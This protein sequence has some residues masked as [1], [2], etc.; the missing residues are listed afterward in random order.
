M[1]RLLA[2]IDK[3]FNKHQLVRR[4][5]ITLAWLTIGYVALHVLHQIDLI[6]EHAASVLNSVIGVCGAVVLFYHYRRP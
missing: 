2:F 1:T 5:S 3:L 6:N 4:V